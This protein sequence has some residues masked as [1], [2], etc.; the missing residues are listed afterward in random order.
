MKR[1]WSFTI[2]TLLLVGLFLA[3]G[4][5][6]KTVLKEE[7]APKESAV[8]AKPVVKTPDKS[9]VAGEAA[10]KRAE[11]EQAGKEKS[12]KAPAAKKEAA[13]KTP[14]KNIYEMADIQFD[15]DKFT[16]RD[17]G[18]A[19]LNKH[20]EWLKKNQKAT[21][22][23]EGHCD[24]RGTAEYNLA[25]GERR[26]DAAAKYLADLGVD[27]KRV[28]TLSYSFERPLDPRHNEE[29]WAKNRRGHFAVSEK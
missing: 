20:A 14:A 18:R 21:V 27:G 4:C 5:A 16:L 11:A 26:A 22:T 9:A 23:V 10:R 17:E 13:A 15:F 8:A 1:S 2:F 7:G 29:A 25:L 28:K 19:T 6:K 3:S 24:E 12:L